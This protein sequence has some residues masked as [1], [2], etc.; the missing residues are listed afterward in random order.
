M[1]QWPSRF[2]TECLKAVEFAQQ[3]MDKDTLARNENAQ[4]DRQLWNKCAE[5]G[6][7]G[8]CMPKEYSGAGYSIEH[9]T[10][11]LEA[12][13]YGCRDNGLTLG[14][15]GQVW[16][17]QEPL[18]KFGTE[19]QKTKYLAGMCRGEIIAAHGMTEPESGSDA[20]SLQ[21]TATAVDEGYVLNGQKI[22]IGLSPVAELL[23][24]FAKTNPDAGGWGISAFLVEADSEGCVVSAG[25]PKQGLNS[26]PAGMIQLTD[27]F[28]PKENR[29]G[30]EGIGMTMFNH[31]MDWERGFIFAS[32]VGSMAR[33]LDQCIEY[34][35]SRRQFGRPVSD[36]QAVSHRVVD[37]KVRYDQARDALY[38]V[39]RLKDENQS[40]TME[41]CLAKLVISE[42]FQANSLDAIRIHGAVGYMTE[43]EIERDLRDATGGVLYSGTSDIQ[44][45]IIAKM[46]GL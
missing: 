21:T 45:N 28:V 25:I 1:P 6:V 39:A 33:Q 27:C 22:Y 30:P 26:N 16:S 15:N 31:S 5:F 8:W 40:A 44:K 24:I 35:K 10:H 14:L 32:H 37:T 38:R 41:A 7:L 46:L 2:E 43:H 13:G 36:F 12:I 42:A 34:C 17:V 29:L 23:L 11:L 18:L 4:F 20:F 19:H 9:T 3:V